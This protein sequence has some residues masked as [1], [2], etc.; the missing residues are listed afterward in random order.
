MTRSLS[1]AA[2]C[3]NQ[4]WQRSVNQPVHRPVHQAPIFA[5]ASFLAGIFA[6]GCDLPARPLLGPADVRG[7]EFAGS[8]PRKTEQEV[9]EPPGE[10]VESRWE[11]WDAYFVHNQHVGYNHVIA[12]SAGGSSSKDIRYVLDNRI[13]ANQGRAR[14]FQRLMQTS[15]ETNDGRLIGFESAL[16]VGPAVTRFVGTMKGENLEV[17]TIRGSSRTVRQVPWLSTYR[18]L[19]G[20]EQ[21]LRKRPMTKKNETRT[22]KLLLPGQYQLA[23]ARLRCSGKASVPLMDGTPAELTEIN[24]EIQIGENQPSYST[25]WTDADGGI[26]RTLSP[27]LQLVAYRTDQATATRIEG[28]DLVAVAIPVTG[29]FARPSEATRVAFKIR[30]LAATSDPENPIELQ[31]V[32]GQYLRMSDEFYQVIVSRQEESDLNGFTASELAP[33]DADQQPNLFVDSTTTLV[34][35]FA[36]AA[37]ASSEMSDR[38]VAEELARTAHQLIAEKREPS[39][40]S[41]ASEVARNGVGDSTEQAILLTALLRARKI[42]SRLAIGI[43]FSPGEPSRMTYHAWTLAHVGGDWLHLDATDGCVAAADRVALLTTNLSGGNEYKALIPLL[44]VIGRIEVEVLGA[45]Y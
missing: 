35:R 21:S 18:G 2:D 17:E 33:S 10:L 8:T 28:D 5:A 15:T 42:P 20:V 24:S 4:V 36:D 45:Q 11:T 25:I 13:Y 12:A 37:I 44:D 27:A 22:L 7:P 34:R 6:A 32:P 23:T 41:R 30:P 19:V 40:F 9:V 3:R 43:K 26:V 39:G 1:R 31:P 29:D 16:Q 38:E 14:F